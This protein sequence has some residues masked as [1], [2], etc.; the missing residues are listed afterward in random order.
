M[1]ILLQHYTGDLGEL[2]I[3]SSE[4]ISAYANKIGAE[5]EL[6]L[7]NKFRPNLAPQIQKLVMLDEKYDE[8]DYVVMVDIDMFVRKGMNENV[9]TDISGVG[10]YCD[11]Q[12]N[13]HAGLHRKYPMMTSMSSP[14]WGGAIYRLNRD[15]RIALRKQIPQI[16]NKM[17]EFNNYL[18]DEGIMS[19]LAFYAGMKI[20]EE[21][22][23]PGNYKWCHCSYRP[24][25]ENAAM[26][27]IRTKTTMTGNKRPKIENYRSLVERNLI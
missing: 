2:E 6:V 9:I 27:H 11:I 8:Y 21:T 23:L 3:L 17:Q 20:N 5:Y 26:I 24:G 13:L 14:Y 4:N 19:V 7:G 15:Q 18:V 10:M 1:D 22:V 25:I 12:Q 16:E